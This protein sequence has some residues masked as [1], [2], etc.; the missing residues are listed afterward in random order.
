MRSG[1]PLSV[2]EKPFSQ[3]Q[4][5]VVNCLHLMS[6]AWL[7]TFSLPHGDWCHSLAGMARCLSLTSWWLC[8][9]RWLCSCTLLLF[10]SFSLAQIF[11]AGSLLW[12]AWILSSDRWREV[13]VKG[14]MVFLGLIEGN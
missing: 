12:P 4:H 3:N 10:F 13:S 8:S 9:P 1:H 5:S 2:C 11:L 6:H 14:R 7:S